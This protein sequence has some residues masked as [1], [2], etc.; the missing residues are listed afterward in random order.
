[1][2]PMAG[3]RCHP[4]FQMCNLAFENQSAAVWCGLLPAQEDVGAYLISGEFDL[5][6]NAT[7]SMKNLAGNYDRLG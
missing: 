1:M 2:P 4:L 7:V 3:R 5:E 6:L